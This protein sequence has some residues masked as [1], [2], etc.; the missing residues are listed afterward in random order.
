MAAGLV[1]LD[2]GV[3]SRPRAREL[4]G[5]RTRRCRSGATT[6]CGRQPRPESHVVFLAKPVTKDGAVTAD[7]DRGRR[8]PHLIAPHGDRD[9]RSRTRLVNADWHGQ[10]ILVNEGLQR[11]G[12]HGLMVL[13]NG[14]EADDLQ[15]RIA[16]QPVRLLGLRRAVGGRNPDRASG[17]RG[18][19]R[20]GP[21]GPRGSTGPGY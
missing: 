7:Q 20:A 11:N 19:A 5:I 15:V 3:S 17:R 13:E 21:A 2:L 6:D 8:S 14:V 9:R 12:R 1:V 4:H 10:A 16:E 18:A